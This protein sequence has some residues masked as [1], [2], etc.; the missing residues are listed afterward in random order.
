MDAAI[1]RSDPL[2]ALTLAAR[3]QTR[4]RVSVPSDRVTFDGVEEGLAARP[5][6]ETELLRRLNEERTAAGLAPLDW[7]ERCADVAREHSQDMYRKGYFG[8]VDLSGNDPFERLQAARVSYLAAGEN[9]AIAPSVAEAH[10]ALMTS[11]Q[12]RENILRARFDEVG[13]GIVHGPYG[14]MCTQMFLEAADD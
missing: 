8:H 2:R 12:H 3:Q 11:E 4:L 14:L 13:I 5:A 7:C 1:A 10:E 9:L 6:S